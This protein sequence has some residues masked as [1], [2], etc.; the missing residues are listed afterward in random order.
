MAFAIAGTTLSLKGK[1]VEVA[2]PLPAVLVS[3]V[4]G[5]GKSPYLICLTRTND[6]QVV[7]TSDVVGLHAEYTR[8]TAVDD[9]VPPASLP[10][11]PGKHC[12]GDEVTLAVAAQIPEPPRLEDVAPEVKDQLDR[13]RLVEE[14]MATHPAREYGNTKKVLKQYR[15]LQRLEEELRDREAALAQSSDR[16]WQEFVSIM[17]VLE[18]FDCLA[19]NQPT[20]LGETA[21]A[22]RGDNEVWL[23]LALASGEFDRLT[24]SQLAAACASL[25]TENARPDTWVDYEYSASVESALSGLRQLRRQLFQQQRRHDIMFPIWQEY[26]LIGLIE[27]WAVLGQKAETTDSIGFGT[28]SKT[29]DRGNWTEFCSHT[30]LDEGDIV[31]VLRRTL[32]FLSQIP[33]VP[34]ISNQLRSNARQAAHWMNRFPVN[35]SLP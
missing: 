9:L 22:I 28:S 13:T 25:V 14:R 2:V 35:E 29:R 32:D 30:S 3:K 7:T 31:R 19:E 10:H 12:S 24:P 16:Y 18:Y 5:S 27:Q 17:A 8:I 20:P 4:P 21:A 33:H 15:R 23:G 6:W 11:K 34:H 1:H 26:D